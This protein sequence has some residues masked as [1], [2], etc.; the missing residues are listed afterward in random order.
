[1]DS[2]LDYLLSPILFGLGG[3]VVTMVG[4]CIGAGDIRRAK[5]IALAGTMIGAGIS[6]A[7]GLIVCVFPATRGGSYA[8]FRH[9]STFR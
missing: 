5:R 1:M 7:V 2:R 3:A 6:E 9:P 4:T 8:V